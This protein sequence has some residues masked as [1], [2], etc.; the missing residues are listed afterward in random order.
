MTEIGSFEPTLGTLDAP[1]AADVPAALAGCHARL[2]EREGIAMFVALDDL[3]PGRRLTVKD[4]AA[5]AEGA[6]AAQLLGGYYAALEAVGFP[7]Q[8]PGEPDVTGARELIDALVVL[9]DVHLRAPIDL[10]GKPS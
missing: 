6:R 1:T 7:A 4:A 3:R 5:R 10:Q 2:L 8:Y 9:S